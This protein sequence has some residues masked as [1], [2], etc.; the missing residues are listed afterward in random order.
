[1][2]TAPKLPPRDRDTLQLFCSLVVTTI[3]FAALTLV[4]QLLKP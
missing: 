2:K 3:I 1:M 4:I